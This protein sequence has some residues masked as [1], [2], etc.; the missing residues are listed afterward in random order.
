MKF[1]SVPPSADEPDV[2]DDAQQSIPLSLNGLYFFL[3]PFFLRVRDETDQ[4]IDPSEFMVRFENR[5]LPQ[6]VHQLDAA[7]AAAENQPETFQ[8]YVGRQFS[9]YAKNS[10]NP[11]HDASCSKSST[12]SSTRYPMHNGVVTTLTSLV[13]A[14][15]PNPRGNGRAGVAAGR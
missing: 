4:L 13:T 2:E 10:M 9:R 11:S 8:Q 12:H 3:Y 14:G 5:Q 7:R 6:L 15:R 1:F